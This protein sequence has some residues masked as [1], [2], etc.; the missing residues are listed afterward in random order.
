[1]NCCLRL[2]NPPL[3]VVINTTEIKHFYFHADIKKLEN[4]P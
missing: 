2:L 1:M 4:L 3:L